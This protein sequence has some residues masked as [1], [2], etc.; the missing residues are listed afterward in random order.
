MAILLRFHIDIA[1]T[2]LPHF[3]ITLMLMLMLFMPRY[4]IL[5][6]DTLLRHFL[7]H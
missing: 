2:L 7:R 3:A 6:H 5:R 1:A 4:M